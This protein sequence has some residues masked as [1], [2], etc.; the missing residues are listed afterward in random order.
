M[1]SNLLSVAARASEAL[2]LCMVGLNDLLLASAEKP[3]GGAK[4]SG[5]GR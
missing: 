4:E 5:T 2:E 1:R 3:H